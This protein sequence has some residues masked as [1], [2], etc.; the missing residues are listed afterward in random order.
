MF[1][2]QITASEKPFKIINLRCNVELTEVNDQHNYG[3]DP[4]MDSNFPDFF[5]V[6]ASR[7]E[8]NVDELSL[9]WDVID[10]STN[11][12]YEFDGAN[13]SNFTVELLNKNNEVV[14][15]LTDPLV[16]PYYTLNTSI[17][18]NLSESLYNDVNYLR[19][20]RVKITSYTTDGRTSE[21]VYIF[22]FPVAAFSNVI[23][24]IANGV[25][26]NYS[27]S[28][29]EYLKTVTLDSA[30]D[31]AF[32]DIY[33]SNSNSV[34]SNIRLNTQDV[35]K[36]YYRLTSQDYYNT[37]IAYTIGQIKLNNIDAKVYDEKPA[38]LTGAISVIYDS[39]L[40]TFDKRL[41]LKWSPNFSNAPL[42]YEVCVT[43][44]GANKI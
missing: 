5:L 14:S 40:K 1:L 27:V 26:I 20:C 41:F 9:S 17:L 29:K 44:S 15:L 21:A 38:N 37:G 18:K 22:S 24:T 39:E 6:V 16:S 12:I 28:E 42:D 34:S 36:L 30:F 33:Q 3:F 19:D 7:A 31:D 32:E 23:T 43:K 11:E 2:N 13:F 4:S 10:P 35:A 8:V 25:F